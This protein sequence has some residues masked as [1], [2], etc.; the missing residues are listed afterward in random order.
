MSANLVSPPGYAERK[1]V[2]FACGGSGIRALVPLL[3]MCAL[4]LGPGH[5]SVVLI[6]PDQS[7]D[8]IKRARDLIDAYRSARKELGAAVKAEGYFRTEVSDAVGSSLVWSPIGEPDASADARFRARIDRDLMNASRTRSLGMIADLLFAD[9]VQEMDMS[10]GFRGVPSIGTVFMNRLRSERF[11]QLMLGDAQ[12]QA[13]TLFFAVGSVFG[14]TGAAALPVVGRSLVERLKGT[15]ERAEIPG[16]RSHRVG[17]ALLLPFFTLPPPES[18]RAPDGGPRPDAA[19]FAQNAAAAMPVYTSK[20][21]GYGSYYVLGDSVPRRQAANEVGGEK[22]ANRA[23][24]V[25][26]FAALAALDF[27][28]RGGESAQE[29]LPIFRGTAVEGKDISWSDLPLDKAS[30]RR[31]MGGCVAAHAFLTLFRPDGDPAPNLGRYLRGVTWAEILG[32]SAKDWVARSGALDAL[33]RFLI[34]TWEWTGELRAGSD[35]GPRL[36]LARSEERPTRVNLGDTIAGRGD[37]SSSAIVAD[38]LQGF[39]HWNTAALGYRGAGFDGFLE[40]LRRGSEEFADSRYAE[41]V[42]AEA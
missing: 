23:H 32:L 7:N 2:Y 14:G 18:D 25:E 8:A 1:L 31:L 36:M 26:F 11:F 39:R 28:S 4:G 13:T 38:G 10:L 21:A 5:L 29:S 3:H 19:L 42:A 37:P 41:R 17:A 27:A 15:E 22:Q 9:S 40:V 6:D 30:R 24:Y 35:D 12:A 16:I 34:K 20:Q 33:G